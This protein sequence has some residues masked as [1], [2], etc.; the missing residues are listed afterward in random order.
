MNAIIENILRQKENSA[1]P[2]DQLTALTTR[3][4]LR[5]GDVLEELKTN[6]DSRYAIQQKH[7]TDILTIKEGHAT[8]AEEIKKAKWVFL[9][10]HAIF[11]IVVGIGLWF[12]FFDMLKADNVE[13]L[14]RKAA[15]VELLKH[16]AKDAAKF[17]ALV[18]CDKEIFKKLDE[19]ADK[20]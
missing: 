11:P 4:L 20:K 14:A 8:L 1:N 9:V 10:A 19:K 18:D 16:E 12:G 3:E 15:D 5:Q 6:V 13:T 7:E 17:Q 2:E